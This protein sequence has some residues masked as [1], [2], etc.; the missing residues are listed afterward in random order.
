MKDLIGSVLVDV[1]ALLDSTPATT[2]VV[3]RLD[4][5][6]AV[7]LVPMVGLAL[8]LGLPARWGDEDGEV[9]VNRMVGAA[10][11][12]EGGWRI[13]REIVFSWVSHITKPVFV[14]ID[15]IGIHNHHLDQRKGRRTD[16]G[17]TGG[18]SGNRS[19]NVV[20]AAWRR[21]RSAIDVVAAEWRM[22]DEGD[23]WGGCLQNPSEISRP[24][25]VRW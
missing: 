1:M 4:R 21:L 2:R 9:G 17:W 20:G 19:L 8:M 11:M 15:T 18:C 5:V 10:D 24:G 16:E 3:T 14:A 12:V 22:R 6:A 7:G 23:A 25:V 13:V